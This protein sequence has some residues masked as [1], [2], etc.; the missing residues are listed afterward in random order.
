MLTQSSRSRRIAL[1]TL[2]IIEDS[3]ITWPAD[4]DREPDREVERTVLVKEIGLSFKFREATL[5]GERDG[6]GPAIRSSAKL[7]YLANR[8]IGVCKSGQ[9]CLTHLNWVPVHLNMSRLKWHF[10]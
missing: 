5:M 2:G 7:H 3:V 9:N 10:W 6:L 4:P 1:C 8:A